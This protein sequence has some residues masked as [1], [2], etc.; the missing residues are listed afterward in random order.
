MEK[1]CSTRTKT[2]TRPLVVHQSRSCWYVCSFCRRDF[3]SAQALGGHMNV[4][5]LDRARLLHLKSPSASFDSDIHPA[6]LQRTT[7]SPTHHHHH[8]HHHKSSVLLMPKKEV[9]EEEEENEEQ[10]VKLELGMGM[11]EVMMMRFP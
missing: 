11:G 9:A 8:H 3:R 4:H 5:R 1:T 2:K 7:F 10:V 6:N